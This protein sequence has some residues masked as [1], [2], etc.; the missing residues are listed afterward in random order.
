M[1]DIDFRLQILQYNELVLALEK[2]IRGE[3]LSVL[4]D[5]SIKSD[6]NKEILYNNANNF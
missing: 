2:N 1:K 3:I 5:R 6:V 4:C